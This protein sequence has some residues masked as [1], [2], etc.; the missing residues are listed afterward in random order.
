VINNRKFSM[1]NAV[2]FLI[3]K[4]ERKKNTYDHVTVD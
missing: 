1:L 3:P 4:I 2:N